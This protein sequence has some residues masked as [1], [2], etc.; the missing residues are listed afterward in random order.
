MTAGFAGQLP[1][2]DLTVTRINRP[3]WHNVRYR[4]LYTGN[5]AEDATDFPWSIGYFGPMVWRYD[6]NPSIVVG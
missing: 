3:P 5:T 2:T 1:V 6:S 4:R